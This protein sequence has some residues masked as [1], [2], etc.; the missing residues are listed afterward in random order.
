M[1]SLQR[2]ELL[3][4]T[5]IDFHPSMDKWSLTSVNAV[6]DEITYPLSNFLGCTVGFGNGEVISSHTSLGMWLL[7]YATYAGVKIKPGLQKA[8]M[9]ANYTLI[10]LNGN[11]SVVLSIAIEMYEILAWFVWNTRRALS[12]SISL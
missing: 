4:L 12:I 8:P 9:E 11:S 1:D 10:H 3:L 7:I 2:M 5:W 6:W